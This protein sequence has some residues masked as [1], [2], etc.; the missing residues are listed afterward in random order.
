MRSANGFFLTTQTVDNKG[1]DGTTKAAE[2]EHKMFQESLEYIQKALKDE[3]I[4][5][6]NIHD[7]DNWIKIGQIADEAR[8]IILKHAESNG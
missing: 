8:D 5:S 7:G 4:R 1:T 6:G 2:A 3:M